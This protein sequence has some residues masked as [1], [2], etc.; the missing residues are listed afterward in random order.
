M[1]GAQKAQPFGHPLDGRVRRHRVLATNNDAGTADASHLIHLGL[2][3]S[4]F[5]ALSME[6]TDQAKLR[7]DLEAGGEQPLL[8]ECEHPL[9]QA[10]LL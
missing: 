6:E 1:R 5:L 7:M 9:R 2:R 3:H 4:H 10:S 8:L